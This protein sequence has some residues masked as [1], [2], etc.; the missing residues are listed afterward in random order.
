MT[1][2]HSGY[3]TLVMRTSAYPT[4]PGLAVVVLGLLSVI[5]VGCTIQVPRQHLV[6]FNGLG[7]P[8]EPRGNVGDKHVPYVPFLPYSEFDE[9]EYL[10]H[11]DAIIGAL[12]QHQSDPRGKRKVV[13]FI[14]GGLNSAKESIE[15]AGILAP[16]IKQDGYFPIFIN[17]DSSFTT[18][19]IDHLF[20]IRQGRLVFDW[21]CNDPPIPAWTKSLGAA[22][23]GTI[24]MPFY[25][26]SDVGRGI[27]RAPV[28]WY[29]L[30]FRRDEAGMLEL[31]AKQRSEEFETR[32]ARGYVFPGEFSLSEGPDART[33]LEKFRALAAYLAPTKPL[34][35]V[36]IDAGGKGAWDTMLRRTKTLFHTDSDFR[37]PSLDTRPSGGLY[38]FLVQLQQIMVTDGERDSW[39]ITLVGHS[40]GTII[41]NE[42]VRI[43]P[44]LPIKNVVYM[45][46]ACSVRDYQDTVFPYLATHDSTEM[47]HLT[48]HPQADQN[49]LNLAGLAIDGS[50]LVWID[51]F[52]ASPLTPMDLVAGRYTNLIASLHNMPSAPQI[53]SRIHIK[54]FGVGNS[55]RGTD[56]QIHGDFDNYYFW[57]PSYWKAPGF[58]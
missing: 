4:I 25:L 9:P 5:L 34:F 49:E 46:A 28:V 54:A 26:L 18:S 42:I 32:V 13:I 7:H 21:C 16:L 37:N 51:E 3:S 57:R 58:P 30:A 52:L 38:K 35:S 50:L 41:L 27:L 2:P 24:T 55:L 8:V 19:Y 20:Y 40:M 44:D 1:M 53:R 17:W 11:M 47:Y 43:F 22:I 10:R 39:E 23:A 14:H 29:S 6:M 15:R 45:A 12:R 48:L 56:P 31:S 33:S 36:A